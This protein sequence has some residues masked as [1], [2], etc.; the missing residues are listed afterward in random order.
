[1]AAGRPTKYDASKIGKAVSA[2]VKERERKHLFPTIEGL[3]VKLGV[4]RDTLYEW[5]KKHPEFSDILEA[6]QAVQ[7]DTLINNGLTGVYNSTITKLML[8]KHKGADGQP[9][10][11][12]QDITTDGKALQV[13]G[14]EIAIRD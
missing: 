13:K 11:D 5:G 4:S 6:L 12:K 14:V 1:M 3:A 2:Y 7:A 9:Y 8:T 10:T